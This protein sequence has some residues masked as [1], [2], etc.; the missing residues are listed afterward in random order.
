V[1]VARKTSQ[2][3][4]SDDPCLFFSRD[5]VNLVKNMNSQKKLRK[6]KHGGKK[7]SENLT[8]NLT[9][10]KNLGPAIH[11]VWKITLWLFNIAMENGPFIDGLPIKN[12]D[13]PWL[14]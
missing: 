4:A 10:P 9:L 2:P 6:N 14:C 7:T 13:F 5:L 11:R 8:L 12:G 1:N 3:T